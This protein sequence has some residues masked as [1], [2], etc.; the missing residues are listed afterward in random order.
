[1]NYDSYRQDPHRARRRAK[2]RLRT[3]LVIIAL[4]LVSWLI[5][6][7]IDGEKKPEMIAELPDIPTG[8]GVLAPL[9]FQYSTFVNAFSEPKSYGP[10][11]QENAPL[12]SLDISLISQP[13]CGQV[14]TAYFAD[15]AFLGDS[16]TEGFTEYN[17]NMSG[18][19]ICGYIGA[20]PNQVVN[21]ASLKHPERGPEVALDVLAAAQ[22]GKLYVLMGANT[23]TILGNDASF[24]AYYGQMLDMLREALPN[25]IIYVQSLTPVTTAA[26]AKN[27]GLENGRLQTL[28]ESLANMAYEKGMVYLNLRESFVNEAGELSEDYAQPDGIHITVSGYEH[29]VD[30]LCRHAVYSADNPWLPGSAFA[31]MSAPV[32]PST[33]ENEEPQN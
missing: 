4:L 1:M 9:P 8:E 31:E 2:R 20:S 26:T 21:K 32:A 11:R 14:T 22:P 27:P 12:R 25:T 10:V 13:A 7:I 19:L 16:I 23:L 18:A 15:A 24:L 33:E 3:I 17:I 30:Y 28:N 5:A 6:R 29:W